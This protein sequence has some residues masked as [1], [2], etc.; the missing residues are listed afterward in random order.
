M[1]REIL[2]VREFSDD[3]LIANFEGFDSLTL[4]TIIAMT[5]TEY[6]IE[7]KNSDVQGKTIGELRNLIQTKK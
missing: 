6:G 7:L 1:M 2:E 3:Q 5:E 4:L